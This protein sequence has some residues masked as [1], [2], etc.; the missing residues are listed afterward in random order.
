MCRLIFLQTLNPLS[1][2]FNMAS[3]DQM[4]T[5]QRLVKLRNSQNLKQEELAH[6]LGVERGTY[7]RYENSN[8]LPPAY[9]LIRIADFFHVTT[10]YLLGRDPDLTL[11]LSPIAPKDRKIIRDMY[12]RL[13][14]PR[15]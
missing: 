14:Q 12:D 2:F 5:S 13:K 6:I 15:P 9:M 1:V 4:T 8:V 11:D 10:D 3:G 7:G